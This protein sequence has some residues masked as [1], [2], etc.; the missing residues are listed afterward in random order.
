MMRRLRAHPVLFAAILGGI[1]GFAYSIAV[2]VGGLIHK[3]SSGVLP[4]LWRGS[5]GGG[6]N[7]ANI[8]QT[9]FVLC[10]EVV[11]NV[12]VYAVM[13]VIPVALVVAVRWA[14][15]RGKRATAS[16]DQ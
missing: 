13:F 7:G 1:V 4:L 15:T 12:V 5:A 11:A 14:F 6:I 10:I 8:S 9:A 2:E 3:S 16:N